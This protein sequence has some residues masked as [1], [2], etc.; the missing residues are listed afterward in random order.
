MNGDHAQPFGIMLRRGGRG[1]LNGTARKAEV[2]GCI[3]FLIAQDQIGP[4]SLSTALFVPADSSSFMVAL[5]QLMNSSTLIAT[6]WG[7]MLISIWFPPFQ[8]VSHPP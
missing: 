7:Y 3:E 1:H 6:A 2:Q 5:D 4:V 8:S